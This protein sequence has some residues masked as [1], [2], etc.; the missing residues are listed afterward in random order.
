[1]GTTTNVYY[2]YTHTHSL[3]FHGNYTKGHQALIAQYNVHTYI[4]IIW[5][6]T[7]TMSATMKV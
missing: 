3:G 6:S 2:A 7:Q 5:V 4:H 1:M